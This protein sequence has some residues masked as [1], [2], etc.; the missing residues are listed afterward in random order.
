MGLENIL[1]TKIT[2]TIPHRAVWKR[3]QHTKTEN[4]ET[5]KEI[6]LEMEFPV[7]HP[8]QMSTTIKE[9]ENMKIQH[10]YTLTP[11]HGFQGMSQ[12]T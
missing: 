1:K 5:T 8:N 3:R 6:Q 2:I 11:K 7:I 9:W 12:Q 10:I 4:S